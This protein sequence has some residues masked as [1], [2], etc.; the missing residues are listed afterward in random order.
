MAKY[1]NTYLL[2]GPEIGQKN[3]FIQEILLAVKAANPGGVEEHRYRAT[4]KNVSDL[5]GLML[6]GSLFSDMLFVVY[7]DIDTLKKDE[8]R[9]LKEYLSEPNP[10]CVCVLTSLENKVDAELQKA[11]PSDSQKIFW[12]LFENQRRSWLISYFRNKGVRIDPDAVEFFMEMVG[13]T[14]DQLRAEA[15]RITLILPQNSSINMEF[16]EEYLQ[17]QREESPFTLFDALIQR[18][19][20]ASLE[21][22]NKIHLSGENQATSVLIMLARQWRSF[23]LFVAMRQK[24]VPEDEVFNELK[25]FIKRQKDSFKKAYTNFDIEECEKLYLL[26]QKFDLFVR[27]ASTSEKKLLID[28]YIYLVVSKQLERKKPIAALALS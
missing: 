19:L 7:S 3:D 22:W 28:Y 27:Q 20:D 10:N 6:N 12:E 23:Y 18:R 25:I 5:V 15:D 11:I 13:N 2:L 1:K 9:R 16:L 24:G 21:I 17:H 14:S 4:D 8:I 26:T